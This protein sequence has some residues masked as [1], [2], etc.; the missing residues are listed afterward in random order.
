[1]D[2]RMTIREVLEST[3]HLLEGISV[4]AVL[5]REIGMP[6][7]GAITNLRACIDAI[8]EQEK[9]AIAKEEDADV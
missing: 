2:E 5:I 7:D 4:P 6:V 9:E 3:M 8:N 1:M